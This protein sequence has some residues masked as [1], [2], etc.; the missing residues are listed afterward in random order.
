MWSTQWSSDILFFWPS[1]LLLK[2]KL[3]KQKQCL[4]ESFYH[5]KKQYIFYQSYKLSYF[6]KKAKKIKKNSLLNHF[7]PDLRVLEKS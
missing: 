6:G 4:F 1:N 5:Y 2:K 3:E 7:Q